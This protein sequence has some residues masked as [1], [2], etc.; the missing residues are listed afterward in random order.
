M[1]GVRRWIRTHLLLAR[2]SNLPTVWSNCVA[3]WLLAGGGQWTD[4][5][6]VFAGATLLY[7]G[8]MYLNDAFDADF[9]RQ[10]RSER[11]IPRGEIS[12]EAVWAI[13]FSMLGTGVLCFFLFS[14]ATMIFALLLSLFILVYDIVHKMF[15]L[16]PVIMAGCRTLL[17]LVAATTGMHGVAGGRINHSIWAA[18]VMGC[19]IVGLS[20]LARR[21]SRPGPLRYWPCALLGAPLVLAFIVNQPFNMLRS[22][23][24]SGAIIL[25]IVRCLRFTLWSPQRN[26]GRTVGG[27]LAGIPLIDLLSVWTGA[28]AVGL[29]FVGFFLLALLFQRFIP[30]T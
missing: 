1:T 8:G 22:A 26:I 29:L 10:H 3:G 20:Y 6:A 16:A 15:A 9:D 17:I 5:G 2:A 14:T 23:I 24:V 27:L 30:A 28:P 13:G 21:E 12:S 25:W 19:Y 7:T 18:L 4:L 11:P